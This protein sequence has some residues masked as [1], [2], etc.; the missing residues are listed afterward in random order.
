MMDRQVTH[1]VRLVD[2]LLDVSRIT[3][4][5]VEL[6]RGPVILNQVLG[7]ARESVQTLLESK[8]HELVMS[9]PPQALSVEGDPD[10]LTQVFANL[11]SNAVKFT[12]RAGTVWLSL[13]RQ[14]DD[15]VVTVRDTGIGIPADKV[16]TVFEMFSQAHASCANDGLG[17]GLAL[18]K[19]LVHM[20]RGSV[21]AESEGPGRGSRFVVRLPMLTPKS[22]PVFRAADQ[23]S[24]AQTGAGAP[25]LRPKRILV[26]D[27]NVD[28]A[29]VLSQLLALQG[30]VVQMCTSGREAVDA[31]GCFAPDV[32]F[33]D[34]GMP[35]IDGLTAAR[36]I[37]E[38]P[39]AAGLQIIALTGWG[40]EADRQQ[41]REAGIDAHL[42]KP[43][44]LDALIALL[45]R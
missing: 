23:P 37:R 11:L 1:L 6:R 28:A 32:I 39:H 24:G 18:V 20:H 10:R 44:D 45:A 22:T 42:V 30:H 43:V 4:G 2:D 8:G 19:Q 29:D 25:A 12:P 16:H 33:M 14:G 31:A 40:Q 5:K 36:L 35:D 26:V 17:I 38:Q 21:S 41:T 27:D 3:R 34:I 13:E 15:A 9:V 7:C